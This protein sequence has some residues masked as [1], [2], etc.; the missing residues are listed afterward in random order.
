MSFGNTI[1]TGSTEFANFVA[2][3]VVTCFGVDVVKT[4]VRGWSVT[5]EPTR[6]TRLARLQNCHFGLNTISTK[7]V[8]DVD[9]LLRGVHWLKCLTP[10]TQFQGE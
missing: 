9:K 2:V 6:L 7:V 4:T 8:D 5:F 3:V 10:M 1:V